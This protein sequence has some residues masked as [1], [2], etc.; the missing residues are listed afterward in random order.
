MKILDKVIEL[1]NQVFMREG[2][3]PNRLHMPSSVW[4]I[5]RNDLNQ[6]SYW[7]PDNHTN[8]DPKF[9]YRPRE[10]LLDGEFYGMKLVIDEKVPEGCVIFLGASNISH[11]YKL[12]GWEKEVALVKNLEIR[13]KPR[14]MIQI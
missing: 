1:S 5:L 9:R 3:P 7:N 8:F 11:C 12:L 4:K 2:C 6:I 13:K 14:R 10:E